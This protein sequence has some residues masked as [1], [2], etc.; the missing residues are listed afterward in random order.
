MNRRLVLKLEKRWIVFHA[1]GFAFALKLLLRIS[2]ALGFDLCKM[3]RLATL[4]LCTEIHTSFTKF[5]PFTTR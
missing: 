1:D 3:S 5:K 4:L 2:T